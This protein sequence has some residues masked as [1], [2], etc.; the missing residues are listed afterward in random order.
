MSHTQEYEA[1]REI[2]R[3]EPWLGWTLLT[4]VPA[5]TLMFTPAA[6]YR[7]LLI[8]TVV[9]FAITVFSFLR[10]VTRNTGARKHGERQ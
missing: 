6:L 10:Q 2:P 9:L 1:E 8:T 4:F 7:P 3:F 5:A